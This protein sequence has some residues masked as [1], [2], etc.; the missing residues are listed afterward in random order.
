MRSRLF[1]AAFAA[2]PALTLVLA[3]VI[4][5]GKRWFS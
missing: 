1:G 4:D 3:I 2:V 5:N